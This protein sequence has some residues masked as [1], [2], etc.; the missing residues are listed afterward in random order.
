MYKM[1]IY[2]VLT[3]VSFLCV[4]SATESVMSYRST[5]P[6]CGCIS[7]CDKKYSEQLKISS[8]V[9]L[10]IAA[11]RRGCRYFH[12]MTRL[13]HK[14]RGAGIKPASEVED[15]YCADSCAGEYPHLPEEK[16]ACL[17]GCRNGCEFYGAAQPKVK[18]TIS[19][20]DDLPAV[21]D[22]AERDMSMS[23]H[24]PVA[25]KE[26]E[27]NKL[28]ASYY[29]ELPV[30][31]DKCCKPTTICDWNIDPAYLRSFISV[32]LLASGITS[33]YVLLKMLQRYIPRDE[34]NLLPQKEPVVVP[35][36][37]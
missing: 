29:K 32:M 14:G 37:T 3:A 21:V 13:P 26:E 17:D 34:Y 10:I 6:R 8:E 30:N 7:S 19:V 4:A 27:S 16:R 23:V 24:Y 5:R 35:F 2:I 31:K 12:I 15:R 11:C 36:S 28:S 20:E 9:Q 25:Q 1:S 22:W 33:L 18:V